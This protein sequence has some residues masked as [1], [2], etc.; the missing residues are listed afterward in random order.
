LSPSLASSRTTFPEDSLSKFHRNDGKSIYQP[1]RRHNPQDLHT[2]TKRTRR[3]T[4]N[5]WFNV[6]P[7]PVERLFKCTDLITRLEEDYSKI[8]RRH[9]VGVGRNSAVGIATCYGLK[10]PGIESRWGRDLPHL[11]RPALGHTQP[12]VQWVPGLSPG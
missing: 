11:S 6:F 4:A 8:S 5:S 10:G 3:M 9:K 12:P 1:S 2:N 7:S